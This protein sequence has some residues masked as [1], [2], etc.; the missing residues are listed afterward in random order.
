MAR[1]SIQIS[2]TGDKQLDAALESFPKKFQNK[3]IKP[4]LRNAMKEVVLTDAKRNTPVRTG[5]LRRSL[6]VRTAKGPNGKRLPRHVVGSALTHAK[7]KTVDGYYGRWVFADAKNRD[8]SIR[9]GTR[10]LRKALYGN[11]EFLLQK[12]RHD[13]KRAIPKIAKEV[14]AALI[15]KKG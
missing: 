9:K 8:G 2:F 6:K 1:D 4:T 14:R 5:M 11:R 12:V 13:W 7:T 10:T 3:V 15:E